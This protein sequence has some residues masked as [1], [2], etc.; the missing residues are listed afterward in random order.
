MLLDLAS[1][2]KEGRVCGETTEM[3]AMH[4]HRARAEYHSPLLHLSHLLP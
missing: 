3:N 2:I 1:E 4:E